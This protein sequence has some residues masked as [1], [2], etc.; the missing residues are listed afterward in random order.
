MVN[1]IADALGAAG[2][3]PDTR[4][5]VLAGDG[6]V[7][8]AGA[9]KALLLQLAR[10]E[11]Q[12]ADILLSRALLASPVPIIAAMAGH[13]IGGGFAL[14]LAADVIVLAAESRYGFTFMNLGFTPGMGT[15]AICEHALSPAIAHELLFTGE[16]RRGRDFARTG[17]NHVVPRAGVL[18]LALDIAARI[19]D[20]PR[21]AVEA[22]KRTLSLPRR[23]ACEAAL[24]FEPLMHQVTFAAAA[25]TGSIEAMYVE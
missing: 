10:G 3:E 17:V 20:K 2:R 23:R 4:A 18:P 22:L 12:P 1:A 8:S 19:A 21:L 25:R 15:T 11:Q 14:G 7:F 16:L 5:I 13:A 6:R 24:T 9:P